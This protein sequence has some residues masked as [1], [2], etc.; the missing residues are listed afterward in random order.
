MKKFG[1]VIHGGAGTITKAT[2]TPDKESAY[3]SSLQSAIETGYKILENGGTAMDAVE[4]AVSELEDKPL[5]NAGKGAVLTHDKKYEMDASIMCGKTL[6]A[7]AIAGVRNIKNPVKLA[8]TVM[9]KS[10]FVLLAGPN[11]QEFARANGIEIESDEYFYT[12]ERYDQLLKAIETGRSFLDH[13]VF[14][15]DLKEKKLGTVGAVALDMNGDL[16]AAT[17]TGGMTNKRYGRVGD[18]PLI[19]CGTYANNKTCAVSCTGSGEYFIRAVAAYDVSAMM[20]YGGKS[21]KEACEHLV[22]VRLKKIN[23]DG[24]LIAIDADCNIDMSFNSEGMYRGYSTND[25]DIFVEIY[26]GA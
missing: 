16:A 10:E 2:M 20:E 23:G 22:F 12:K 6:E 11:A 25:K 5:F 21:L 18:T 26:G 17:S 13:T 19:G 4:A 24:G 7:G 15:E 14:Q 8:R 3:K 9:E 1:I